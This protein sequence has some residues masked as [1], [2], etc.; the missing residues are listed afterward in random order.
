MHTPIP[1]HQFGQ[2]SAWKIPSLELGAPGERPQHRVR[3]RNKER[4]DGKGGRSGAPCQLS[5]AHGPR[6]PPCLERRV[7]Q[8]LASLLLMHKM[9]GVKNTVLTTAASQVAQGVKN[10]PAM[11]ETWIRSLCWEYP[12]E[13]GRATHP[14]ILAW[15]IPWTEE[16][17]RL[18]SGVAES[19]MI[20]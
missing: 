3:D 15:R 4:H 11:W 6:Y 8:V 2:L 13:K 16:P 19:D 14:S 10:L 20:E 18:Q 5:T 1:T 9:M 7:Q 17:G 12:L